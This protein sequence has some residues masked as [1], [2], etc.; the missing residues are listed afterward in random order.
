MTPHLAR[1]LAPFPEPIPQAF[2]L[3]RTGTDA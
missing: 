1:P 3:R 2:L